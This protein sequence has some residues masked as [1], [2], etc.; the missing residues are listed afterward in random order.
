MKFIQIKSFEGFFGSDTVGS[1]VEVD[2]IDQP[3]V[4]IVF[5]DGI[6][7][8]TSAE[9]FHDLFA[10]YVVSDSND[11][12]AVLGLYQKGDEYWA[13]FNSPPYQLRPIDVERFNAWKKF[14]QPHTFVG[15]S[16][17]YWVTKS[18]EEVLESL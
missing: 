5:P 9:T 18:P 4:D 3:V 6:V 15:E 1:I 8:C 13:V 16:N 11:N 2:N 14:M 17:T 7:G 12:G 10:P